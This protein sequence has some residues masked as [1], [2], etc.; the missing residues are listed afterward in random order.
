MILLCLKLIEPPQIRLTHLIRPKIHQ[1]R[2]KHGPSEQ[3][4]RNY[5]DLQD[6]LTRNE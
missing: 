6:I 1:L 5:A 2:K 3:V 4:N